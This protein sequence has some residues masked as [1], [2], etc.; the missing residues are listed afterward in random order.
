MAREAWPNVLNAL[1]FNIK[2]G[3]YFH[4]GLFP[5]GLILSKMKWIFSVGFF[6][7]RD[8]TE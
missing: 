8:E 2:V 4:G 3:I 1:L 7:N 6:R 5:W